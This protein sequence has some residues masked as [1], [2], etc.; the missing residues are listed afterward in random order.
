MPCQYDASG[1][2]AGHLDI[3]RPPQGVEL[4][5]QRVTAGCGRRAPLGG[6]D[7]LGID[8][9]READIGSVVAE[10]IDLRAGR[11]LLGEH[12]GQPGDGTAYVGEQVADRPRWT[13]GGPG[14]A[15]LTEREHLCRQPFSLRLEGSQHRHCQRSTSAISKL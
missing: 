6:G 1:R 8:G 3:H 10:R 5:G 7:P 4:H 15:V 9:G 11:R 13:A 12:L 14:E 2:L